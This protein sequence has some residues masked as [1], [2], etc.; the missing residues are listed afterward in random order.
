MHHF[1][2]RDGV[3]HAEDVS[4]VDLAERV[5][6][7]AYVYSSATLRRHYSLLAEAAAKLGLDDEAVVVNLQGDEPEIAP[8]LLEA[9]AARLVADR[10][11][12]MATSG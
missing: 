7:P 9:V 2:Q 5:G 12:S 3:L 6:T 1:T 10:D 11:A 4:L 8:G